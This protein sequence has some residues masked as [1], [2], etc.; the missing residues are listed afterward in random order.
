M[1]LWEIIDGA[2]T[3]FMTLGLIIV[4]PPWVVYKLINFLKE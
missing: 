3:I 4:L 2:E 1:G